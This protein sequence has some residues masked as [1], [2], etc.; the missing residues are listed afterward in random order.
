M[1]RSL[2]SI[3]TLL[4]LT[5]VVILAPAIRANAAPTPAPNSGTGQALEIAPPVVNLTANPGQTIRTE[6]SLRDV[7][8]GK[9]LV[10]SQVNDFIAAGEDGTPKILLDAGEESPYSLKSWITPLSSLLLS[11]REIKKLPVVIKVPATAAPGG[12]YGVVRF[13]ASA[14]EMKDTGVS[15]SA[16]LGALILVR[17]NGA[18]K[19]NL[20][21]ETLTVNT[22][23]G[24]TYDEKNEGK[25]AAVFQSTPIQ[26]VERI[27]NNGNVHEQPSGQVIIRNMFGKTIA[28]VN[29]N[30]PPR[31]ILPASVRKFRQ[32]LDKEVIGNK[33]LFGKYTAELKVV[34]GANKQTVSKTTTFWVIPYS[35]IIGVIIALVVGFF[36]LRIA[37]KR[38]NRA[39]IKKARS[40]RSRRN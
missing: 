23:P 6:L 2:L 32:P 11:P 4:G 35:L 18:A 3:V 15:L 31:N 1:K 26:F 13:T 10:S 5:S 9:L 38:Y 20:S 29:V 21:I 8:T 16:S 24:G 22:V 40:Q 30:L 33:Q 37:I 14:P 28:A 19:E 7:S 39:I 25:P 36:A 17:V 27:K 12:Y 34:Y